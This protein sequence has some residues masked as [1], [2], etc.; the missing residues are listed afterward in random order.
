ME[1]EFTEVEERVT[2]RR[3]A[4]TREERAEL[5]ESLKA[6]PGRWAIFSYHKQIEYASAFA[7]NIRSGRR[8]GWLTPYLGELQFRAYRHPSRGPVVVVRWRVPL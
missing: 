6:R 3:G 5:I 1:I 7:C 2:C 8:S 4:R